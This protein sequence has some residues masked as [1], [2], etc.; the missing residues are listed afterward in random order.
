MSVY[1]I[2][3]LIILGGLIL[4]GILYYWRPKTA[5]ML[6]LQVEDEVTN[7][8]WLLISILRA[9][10]HAEL[11]LIDKTCGETRVILLCLVRR[12]HLQ[13]LQQVPDG[14]PLLYVKSD[15]TSE[16]LLKQ[17]KYLSNRKSKGK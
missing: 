8:E 10:P 3:G 1:A 11:I 2:W 16:D 12:Y 6:Y 14:V 13:L 4:L 7:I 5:Q 17:Y 9:A 15:T